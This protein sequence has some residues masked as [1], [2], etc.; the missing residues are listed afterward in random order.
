MECADGLPGNKEWIFV[1]ILAI[2]I[3]RMIAKSVEW[4]VKYTLSNSIGGVRW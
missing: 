1:Y 2:M 3:F 4:L